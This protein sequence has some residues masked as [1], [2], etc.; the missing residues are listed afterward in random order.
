MS[1]AKEAATD[2]ITLV[3]AV[4]NIDADSPDGKTLE[5]VIGRIEF[6]D[7]HFRYR[8]SPL[9]DGCA[10]ILSFPLLATRPGAQVLRSL[11]FTIEPGSYVAIVGASGSGYATFHFSIFFPNLFHRK[12]TV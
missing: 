6:R 7:V 4:P 5:S 2:M 1:S 11:E 3:D 8:A 9:A 10:I 12:S